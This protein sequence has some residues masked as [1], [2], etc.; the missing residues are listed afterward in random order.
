MVSGHLADQL[1]DQ[2]SELVLPPSSHETA[3]VEQVAGQLPDQLQDQ[4]L[5]VLL[6]LSQLLEGI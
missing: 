2:L 5:H 3:S 1:P 4:L 6:V